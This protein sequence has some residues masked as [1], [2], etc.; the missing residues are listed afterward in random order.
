MATKAAKA[1]KLKSA[2]T[3]S[4]E[5]ELAKEKLAEMEVDESFI[6][7]D[8]RRLRIRRQSDLNMDANNSEGEVIPLDNISSTSDE[9][10]DCPAAEDNALKKNGTKVSFC[11]DVRYY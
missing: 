9:S 2:E 8:E 11:S 7:K 10:N 6:Q 4:H 3:R 1:A 5:E